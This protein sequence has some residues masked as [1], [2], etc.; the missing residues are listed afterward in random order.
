M[1][2]YIY[3]ANIL[4]KICFIHVKEG[5]SR[6]FFEDPRLVCYFSI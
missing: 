3:K 5:F 4:R 2:V 1:K 6:H